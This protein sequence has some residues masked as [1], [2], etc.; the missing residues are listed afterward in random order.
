MKLCLREADQSNGNI[1]KY[2]YLLFFFVNF[3]LLNVL[4]YVH[5]T[6]YRIRIYQNEK[7]DPHSKEMDAE[8]SILCKLK[9][10]LI[11]IEFLS[12][13]KFYFSYGGLPVF[14]DKPYSSWFQDSTK[15]FTWSR[16]LESS[17]S[18]D[19]SSLF[20]A[21]KEKVD[22]IIK[23]KN[24]YWDGGTSTFVKSHR[25]NY[26]GVADPNQN[27]TDLYPAPRLY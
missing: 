16:V 23:R 22:T 25:R 1:R 17:R 9:E 2:F 6:V 4:H 24:M 13:D 7:S 18:W 19:S 12:P 11:E 8:T 14:K 10:R 27:N 21:I 26:I 20:T 15:G 5:C 3:Y